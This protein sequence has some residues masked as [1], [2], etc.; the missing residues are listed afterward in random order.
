MKKTTI[1]EG[2]TLATLHTEIDRYCRRF[3]YDHASAFEQL[4]NLM[5]HWL[6]IEDKSPHV[7][8]RIGNEAAQALVTLMRIF[9]SVLHTELATRKWVDLFGDYFMEYGA[10]KKDLGQCFTPDS[11][12]EVLARLSLSI[13]EGTDFDTMRHF[14]PGFGRNVVVNDCA[15]GSG[16]LLLAAGSTYRHITKRNDI[17]LTASD[18]DDRCCKQSAINLLVHGFYGEVAC[19]DT[20]MGESSFSHGWIVNQGLY[21]I[22]F[23]LPSLT[24]TTDKSK[25]YQY[26][27]NIIGNPPLK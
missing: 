9:F 25:F 1:L 14:V 16:R 17:Y 19:M 4:L 22:P 5:V 2:A 8:P 3:G 27:R 21:P 10:N 18:I 20:L 23:G 11:V 26:Q 13:N 12:C 7:M 24:Y 15:C 6:E